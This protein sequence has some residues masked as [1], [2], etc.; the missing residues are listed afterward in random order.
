MR[1]LPHHQPARRHVRP[2]HEDL[3]VES[4]RPVRRRRLFRWVAM[5]LPARRAL[6]C[7]ARRPA[8]PRRHQPG[9]EMVV[10][11]R[12]RPRDRP[13]MRAKRRPIARG[14]NRDLELKYEDQTLAVYPA[15]VM[16]PPYPVPFPVNREAGIERYRALL[17]PDEYKARLARGDTDG[18]GAAIHDARRASRRSS[19]CVLKRRED[20]ADGC[21]AFRV[22]PRRWRRTAEIRRRRACRRRDRAGISA[23]IQPG[24]RPGR[25][26]PKYVLGVQ[27]E[28]QGGAAARC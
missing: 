6:D 1:A 25:P 20:M 28:P 23:A 27:R 13:H 26:Q 5:H 12:A 18:P 2:L 11:Y 17:T 8:R 15:D 4:G 14:L 22:R 3:P 24:R 19:R 10:G 16:P 21:R 9:Q 7:R